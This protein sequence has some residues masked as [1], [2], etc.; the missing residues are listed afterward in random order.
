MPRCKHC[1][2]FNEN[3]IHYCVKCNKSLYSSPPLN[4]S[5]IKKNLRTP[6]TKGKLRY[7]R[8]FSI[9]LTIIII[10]IPLIFSSKIYAY[11]T[12]TD[13]EK[14]IESTL[15]EKEKNTFEAYISKADNYFKDEDYKKSKVYLKKALKINKESSLAQKKY[16]KTVAKLDKQIIDKSENMISGKYFDKA[17][18]SLKTISSKT[19]YTDE[20]NKYYEKAQNQINYTLLKKGEYLESKNKKKDAIATYN[21]MSMDYS[22]YRTGQ[23]NIDNLNNPK[24]QRSDDATQKEDVINLDTAQSVSYR[25]LQKSPEKYKKQ[26]I[27]LNGIIGDIQEINAKTVAVVKTGKDENNLEQTVVILFPKRTNLNEG[28]YIDFYGYVIG[29]FTQ[30]SSYIADY[31]NSAYNIYFPRNSHYKQS[32][33][34]Q[35]NYIMSDTIY[36]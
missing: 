19:K 1:K 14:R 34:I 5:N 9:F 15:S 22:Y 10:I 32:P 31:L 27:Y 26:L 24:E 30:T 3:K 7:G 28:D 33:V 13:A 16:E 18:K 2:H 4:D 20:Q 17:I 12:K 29:G 36:N 8:I 23:K 25:D 11:F 6:R 21:K 35:S